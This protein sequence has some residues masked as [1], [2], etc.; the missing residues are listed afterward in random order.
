ML[1]AR[2][3]F[4]VAT[5]LK[6]EV[7]RRYEHH[8][9]QARP[10][11]FAFE[12]SL[13]ASFFATRIGTGKAVL[14][15]GC[16]DGTLASAYVEGNT[17]TGVDIDRRALDR[18]RAN[19]LDT[20]WA[21]LTERLPLADSRFDVVVAG[22]L[23]EHL[24]YPE[25]LLQEV[26]RVLVPRGLFVG[27]VPNAFRLKNRLRVLIG[28]PP[29]EDPTHLQHFSPGRLWTLLSAGF[30]DVEIEFVASRFLRLSPRL[31]GNTILFSARR[32]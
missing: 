6:E 16:R 14:D 15:L 30:T 29:E 28:R 21:D 13:R 3:A 24:P 7:A 10:P 12:G 32:R 22:E 9:G 25:S 31:F 8:H 23:L 26:S 4:R 1:G 18:A 20:V 17:V 27:S 11:G 2:P 19:G 5:V